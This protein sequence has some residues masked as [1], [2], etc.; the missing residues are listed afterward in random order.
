MNDGERRAARDASIRN[1]LR[2]LGT[3][4]RADAEWLADELLKHCDN[5]REGSAGGFFIDFKDKKLEQE[6]VRQAR[7]QMYDL[8]ETATGALYLFQQQ[9]LQAV[10]RGRPK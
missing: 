6:V 3:E 4:R 9:V 2:L 7:E 10:V 8:A 5:I 1:T